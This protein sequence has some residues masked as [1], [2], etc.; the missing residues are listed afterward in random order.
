MWT[1]GHDEAIVAFR[2]FAKAPNNVERERERERES[3]VQ[4]TDEITGRRHAKGRKLRGNR[5]E[6]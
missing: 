6:K 3:Q 4:V 2:N 5:R 1:G